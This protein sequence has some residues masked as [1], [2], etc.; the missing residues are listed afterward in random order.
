MDGV[1]KIIT[2]VY[3]IGRYSEAE[4]L[5]VFDVFYNSLTR[6]VPAFHVFCYTNLPEMAVARPNVTIFRHY[7]QN[8]ERKYTN[9]WNNLSFNRLLIARNH[10]ADGAMWLDLDSIVCTDLSYT[11]PFRNF[12]VRYNLDILNKL[13]IEGQVFHGRDYFLGHL[14]KMDHTALQHLLELAA[15]TK[16]LPPYDV[17][18]YVTLLYARAPHLLTVLND[19]TIPVVNWEWSYDHPYPDRIRGAIRLCD[20]RLVTATGRPFGVLT[21]TFPSLLANLRANWHT[22]EDLGARELLRNLSG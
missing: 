17:Q 15:A 10:L 14:W 1:V 22:L 21:F 7:E 18:D 3:D 8:F 19:V 20:G 13:S 12:V 5:E 2:M 6:F 11:L 16:T 4:L 9:D